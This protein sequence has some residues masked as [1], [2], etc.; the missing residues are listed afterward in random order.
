MVSQVLLTAEDLR[1]RKRYLNARNTLRVLLARKVIPIINENDTVSVEEIRFGDNDVL[2]A[3]VANLIEA[4]LLVILSDVEGFFSADPREDREARLLPLV[5]EIGPT[6][7]SAAGRTAGQHGLGGMTSKLEAAAQLMKTGTP[8]VLASGKRPG[9][10]SAILAGEATGT[11]FHRPL[12][13][14]TLTRRK[15]WLAYVVRPKGTLTLDAGACRA[16]SEQGKSLLASGI[17]AVAGKFGLGDP[18]LCVDEA[19]REIAR[20]L[21][22]Y[23]SEEV[24]LILGKHSSA[25]E[26][27]LGYCDY[28]EVIHRDNLAL[29]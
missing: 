21:A 29:P 18:V 16:V 19:G 23:S 24:A 15:H 7:R 12:E 27:L 17:R 8:T 4:D 22:N 9:T 5:E 2:G 26:Q 25:I 3:Q 13:G 6:Q 10:L 20:G 11:L 14:G 1:D 28:D